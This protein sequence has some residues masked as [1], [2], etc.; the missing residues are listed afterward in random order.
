[1]RSLSLQQR[2]ECF[3]PFDC[4]ME[5]NCKLL[6][7]YGIPQFKYNVGVPFHQFEASPKLLY[8]V[9]RHCC[10]ISPVPEGHKSILARYE[11]VTGLPHLQ[12]L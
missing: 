2:V 5:R 9:D 4:P 8:G 1:M 12:E 3:E 6:F 11:Q 7:N 10:R